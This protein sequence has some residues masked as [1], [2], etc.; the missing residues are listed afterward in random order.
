VIKKPQEWGGHHGP[1]WAAAP[2]GGGGQIL[3]FVVM[4]GRDSR[5]E[6]HLSLL[7]TS[8]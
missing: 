6:L 3:K 4:A 2:R 5:H 1:R 8:S 7:L